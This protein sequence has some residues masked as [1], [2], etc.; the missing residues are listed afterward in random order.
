[1]TE[2][3]KILIALA[4]ISAAFIPT[5]SVLS[6]PQNGTVVGGQASISQTG[7]A[8]SI[9]QTTSRAIINWQ[10]FSTGTNESVQFSQPS[11]QSVILNRVTGTTASTLNGRLS[12]N[13]TVFLINPNGVM[14]GPAGTVDVG[15]FLATTS[16]I[17]D[18]EFLAGRYSFTGAPDNSQVAN[19]GTIRT[20]NNRSVILSAPSVQNSGTI[21]TPWGSTALGA[22]KS[23]TAELDGNGLLQYQIGDPTTAAL[24]T[25]SGNIIADGGKVLIAA[26]S[27]DLVARQVINTAGLVEANSVAVK[28][29]EI[30]FDGGSQG[31]VAVSGQVLAEGQKAGETGGTVTVTGDQVAARGLNLDASGQSGG[32]SISLGNWQ[33]SSTSVDAASHLN[34]SA[35][36]NGN[37][38]SISVIGGQTLVTGTLLATG[39]SQSGDGGAVETSGHT[40]SVGGILVNVG[41]TEGRAGRWLLDPADDLTVDANLAG[42]INTALGSGSVTLQTSPASCTGVACPA[43]NI[44]SATGNGDIIVNS[45]INWSTNS[46]LT[47]NAY[48][49]ITINANIT[50]TG[51]SPTLVLA[52]GQGVTGYDITGTG[53]S[54]TLPATATLQ[55]CSGGGAVCAPTTYTPI[56][57]TSGIQAMS[58]SGGTYAI[59]NDIA[60]FG[61]FAAAPV[62]GFSGVCD[63]LGHSLGNITIND[64]A[65]SNVGLFDINSGG[66]IRNINLTNVSVNGNATVGAL[67]GINDAGGILLNDTVSGSVS[68][69]N[70]FVGGLVGRNINN[71][72][73]S[74]SNASAS[75]SSGNGSPDVGG[76][77]G[78]LFNSTIS[79]SFATGQVSGGN[80]ANQIGGLAGSSD[81]GTIVSSYATG[82]V[83][84]T[85]NASQIGGLVGLNNNTISS[86]YATGSVS[87]GSNTWGI[88]GLVGWNQTGGHTGTISSSYAT[89]SVSGGG[90]ATEIGGLVGRSQAIII[91]SYWD[92]DTTNQ[93]NGCNADATCSGNATGLTDTAAK[94]Q[95]SYS[96]FPSTTWYVGPGGGYPI[97]QTIGNTLTITPNSTSRTY[98]GSNPSLTAS[99]SGLTN[100]D[101]SAVVSNLNLATTAIPA[102]AVGSYPITASGASATV[103]Q[104]AYGNAGT[105]TVSTAPLTVTANSDSKTYNGLPYSGGNSVSYSA[106]VNGETSTV[107]GGTLSYGGNSQGAINSGNY[108]ITPQGLTASN[109]SITFASGTLSV[110]QAALTITAN[111]ASKAY[112]A[113]NPTLSASYSGWV[114]GDDTSSLTTAP[115]L[116]TTA[117]TASPVGSYPITASGAINPNYA[118]T[119]VPG[120]LSVGQATLTITANNANRPYGSTNPA[121]SAAYSGWVNGDDTS[122]LTTAPTLSTT[123]T[124]ASPAG[125]YPITPSGA[126]SPNYSITYVPGTLAV[127]QAALTITANTASKTYGAANPTLSAAY[128]GWVNGDDTSSLTTAPTLSTTATSAS[129]AGSY[130]ITPSGA[131]SPNYSITYVPGTLAVG[132]AAL[133]ITANTAS[134]TYGSAN[135]ALSVSYSGWVNGD[136]PSSLTTAPT[137]VTTATATSPAGSYPINP[138]GAATPNYSI[139]YVPGTLAVGQAALTI[140]AN[141]ASKTYGSANPVLSVSYSGWVNGDA[142]SS[143]TT[144]PTVVTT[145]TATSPAGSYPITP[146]GAADPNYSFTY[147]PGTLSV[148]GLPTATTSIV[149][150]QVSLNTGTAAQPSTTTSVNPAT[151]AAGSIQTTTIS[152]AIP[153]LRQV[154]ADTTA[155]LNGNST[156]P[157]PTTVSNGASTSGIFQTASDAVTVPTPTSG[158]SPASTTDQQASDAK[159]SSEPMYTLVA[160]GPM[161]PAN[162]EPPAKPA[163][164]S[165]IP[166][167]LNMVVPTAANGTQANSGTIGR[168]SAFGNKALW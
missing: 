48:R 163:V 155:I 102:S 72:K 115:T 9:Q 160:V 24:V 26:R 43:G 147:V 105:L 131:V 42:S 79:S 69:V 85:S 120:T 143:L 17:T 95:G 81:G 45:P 82:S 97:L 65:G 57:D 51:T 88:G 83:G 114:N 30:Y 66:I 12:S 127:G 142:P 10:G 111:N 14:V 100:G 161:P 33:S 135:P 136:A 118:I 166:G 50:A 133:T 110:G 7:T 141:N 98:G 122:S 137:V 18:T 139:T 162:K 117:T 75:V 94:Q 60:N 35:T 68:A 32:G 15:S 62:T 71:S 129:P 91:S 167:L 61:T 16:G 28:N 49:N 130:P 63:G 108:T 22:A 55:M 44:N 96:W 67:A 46:S 124:S 148:E 93:T 76:L 164:V 157:A 128:S 154:V 29:G 20:A 77:V 70:G 123:A 119:Y 37:G 36:T 38:G 103:Y 53:A 78:W 140:T 58:G 54:I 149:V 101:T 23:F 106:F 150:A 112:G 87:G 109:Y 168:H 89:G 59:V 156:T 138:S 47:L 99:Y 40:L 2:R 116:S 4:M 34:A 56:V 152:G 165:V 113:A 144:A 27:A 11:G 158:V 74:Y 104:I 151:N 25:N 1:M 39:G 159:P 73:I 52:S 84:G 5:A 90:G 86:S 6:A 80:S 121:L 126:V 13:G 3:Q 125:S 31:S 146:S 8:T 64:P 134:K 21:T 92:K 153:P 145:A 41:A 132:Q 19:Q 107:L